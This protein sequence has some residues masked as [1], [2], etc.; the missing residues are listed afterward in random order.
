MDA[1]KREL[2]LGPLSKVVDFY[3]LRIVVVKVLASCLAPKVIS[4]HVYGHAKT[5]QVRISQKNSYY[6]D[7]WAG[8]VFFLGG[9]S[10]H[11]LMVNWW[12]G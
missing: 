7:A 1:E 3:M 12:F 6:I 11:K 2:I 5:P 9:E 10:S 4:E 8:S